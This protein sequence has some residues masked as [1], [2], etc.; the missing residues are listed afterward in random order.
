MDNHLVALYEIKRQS[1]L[2]GFVQSPERFDS[3]L[4]FA[5]Y[6]R[7]APYFHDSMVREKYGVDPYEEV[8]HVKRELMDQV[9]KY[10][11]ECDLQKKYDEIEFYKLEDRF[12]GY[13]TNRI[14]LIY[15]L[16][17]ARIAR[18]FN[19]NVWAAIEKDA[20]AEAGTLLAQ[21]EPKDVE[22]D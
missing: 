7:M 2:I 18:R 15:T 9:L 16:E 22:F 19:T 20:P 6:H 13:K 3:A 21:F 10:V 12:G 8:Y 5:Y 4:A 11:D 17:Y 1:F 14:E